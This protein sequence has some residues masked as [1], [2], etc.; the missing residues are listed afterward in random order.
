MQFTYYCC[1]A[2]AMFF[3]QNQIAL[4]ANK[5]GTRPLSRIRHLAPLHSANLIP[6]IFLEYIKNPKQ[7][8]GNYCALITSSPG[9][10]SVCTTLFSSLPLPL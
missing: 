6:P 4:I 7:T 3:L 8:F 9:N 2:A 5:N 1:A 10:F